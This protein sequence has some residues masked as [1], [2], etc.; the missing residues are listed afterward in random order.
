MM[1]IGMVSREPFVF[2]LIEED[3]VV[4]RIGGCLFVFVVILLCR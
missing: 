3:I 4:G 1:L 2:I